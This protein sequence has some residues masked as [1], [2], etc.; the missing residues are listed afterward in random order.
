MS[1][2]FD[3][4]NDAK[5]NRR[6]TTVLMHISFQSKLLAAITEKQHNI[7]PNPYKYPKGRRDRFQP[8]SRDELEQGI[9]ILSISTDR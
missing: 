4:R 9:D 3:P 1:R 7:V 8:T 2:V 5:I 6:L